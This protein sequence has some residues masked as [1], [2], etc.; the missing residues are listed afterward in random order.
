MK[1]QIRCLAISACAAILATCGGGGGG[2]E[3][4]PAAPPPA[5]PPPAAPPPAG[6]AM[7]EITS[8]NAPA[9]TAG[10]MD[11]VLG[12][13]L[14]A[15]VGGADL[16]LPASATS[17]GGT[18]P[19]AGETVL[20]LIRLHGAAKQLIRILVPVG[21]FTEPCLISGSIT[22]SGDIQSETTLTPGIPLLQ[23]SAIATTATA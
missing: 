19:R 10:T 20:K 15:S 11:A 12:T 16:F 22:F 2:G 9:I 7:A 3:A 14:L 23:I 6:P 13:A 21:P 8:Q 17:T 4:P 5:A 1:A 18:N